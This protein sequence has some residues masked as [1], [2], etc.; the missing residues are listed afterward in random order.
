MQVLEV[1]GD[2]G[3]RRGLQRPNRHGDQGDQIVAVAPPRRPL[4][5]GRVDEAVA[6]QP[7]HRAGQRRAGPRAAV[8]PARAFPGEGAGNHVPRI[9]RSQRLHLGQ[10]GV[11]ARK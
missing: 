9:S 4:Q 3:Q 10:D 5:H 8:G 6:R 1:T 11:T 7:A 2:V